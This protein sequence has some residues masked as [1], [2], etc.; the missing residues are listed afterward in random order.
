MVLQISGDYFTSGR[1]W[2]TSY[3]ETLLP[4]GHL[5]GSQATTQQWV[6][7]TG[8]TEVL[9]VRGGDNLQQRWIPRCPWHSSIF[10]FL[11]QPCG[12]KKLRGW[13][14]KVKTLQRLSVWNVSRG[15]NRT[16]AKARRRTKVLG[17]NPFGSLPF[18]FSQ[19]NDTLDG[20]T[21][22]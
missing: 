12:I 8:G 5:T 17:Y 4:A 11:R 3:S 2:V 22:S 16:I 21:N 10:L 13:E 1:L 14:T 20:G 18:P 19:L 7:Q 15:L 6:F 9:P